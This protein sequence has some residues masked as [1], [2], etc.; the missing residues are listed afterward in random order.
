MNTPAT[1][2][3][4]VVITGAAGVL[5]RAVAQAFKDDDL[6]LVDLERAALEKAHGPDGARRQLVALDLLDAA[7][8]AVALS[9]RVAGAS[10]L[11]LC[12]V[13]GGFTMG[14]PVHE[15]ADEIWTRMLDLNVNTLVHASRAVVPRMLET[16]FGKIVNVAAASAVSGKAQ[17]GA[18]VAAK[19][20][21]ARITET[22][23]QELRGKGINVNAVAPSIID[24]PA[25]RAAMPDADPTQWVSA[26][27]LANVI[28]FLAS[29]EAGAVHG[30][31]MPVVG[32]S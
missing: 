1:S 13:A 6:V 24:T 32:L 12:N 10:R 8:T 19:S 14:T 18:Y 23:S 28:R 16:G 22:L 29:D 31:V 3:R 11:V 2:R 9:S 20:G 21:V 5:G 7:A 15:T 27:D 17:M 26:Q 4:T 30:V 25:N